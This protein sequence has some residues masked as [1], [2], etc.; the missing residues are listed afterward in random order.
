MGLDNKEDRM[1]QKY[2]I[3]LHAIILCLFGLTLMTVSPVFAQ[4]N[5][6][7][8]CLTLEQCGDE[9]TQLGERIAELIAQVGAIITNLQRVSESIKGA[10]TAP[11]NPDGSTRQDTIDLEDGQERD[12]EPSL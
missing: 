11:S 3:M 10:P 8:P 6:A 4:Q 2:S 9:V 5:T 7:P 1:L 12:Q